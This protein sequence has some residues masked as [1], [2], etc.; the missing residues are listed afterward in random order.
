[1]WVVWERGPSSHVPPPQGY[2]A[3]FGTNAPWPNI[4][5]NEQTPKVLCGARMR[6]MR[7]AAADA[8]ARAGGAVQ[9]NYQ[10]G[11]FDP[12]G[13]TTEQCGA[14]WTDTPAGAY[15]QLMGLYHMPLDGYNT[16]PVRLSPCA[17]RC[18][19]VPRSLTHVCGVVGVSAWGG[20]AGGGGG[21]GVCRC[22][23]V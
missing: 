21:A 17:H 18:C 11:I 20:G 5:G 7:G 13:F 23:L 4:Q 12:V 19:A 16:I 8:R 2:K 1:M 22:T 9:D 10:M 3:A 6:E 15:C 14:G